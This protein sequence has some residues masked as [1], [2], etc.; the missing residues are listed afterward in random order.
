ML[1]KH[2]LADKPYRQNHGKKLEKWNSFAAKL[3]ASPDFFRKNLT[4]KTA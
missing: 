3:V 2:A 1:L 4:G